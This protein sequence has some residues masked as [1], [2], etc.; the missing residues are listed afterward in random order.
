MRKS[1]VIH[2]VSRSL[3]KIAAQDLAALNQENARHLQCVANGQADRMSAFDKRLEAAYPNVRP[4]HLQQPAALQL[5]CLVKFGLW[6][7]HARHFVQPVARKKLGTLLF[8]A[9][10]YE[11]QLRSGRCDGCALYLRIGQRFAAE[12]STKVA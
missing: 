3:V 12:R 11:R 6:I 4:Q 10:M 7:A 8:T 9:H 1:M 5:E 2:A